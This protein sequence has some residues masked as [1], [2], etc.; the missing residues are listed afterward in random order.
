MTGRAALEA[1][2]LETG[3]SLLIP[4]LATAA[5][6]V[7]GTIAIAWKPTPQAVRAVAASMPFITRAKNVVVM[8]VEEERAPE[9]ADRLVR[10]LAWHGCQAAAVL[11]RN[12]GHAVETLFPAA[13][14]SADLLVMGGYGHSRLRERAFGGFI[15]RALED[16]P[17]RIDSP[18]N[19]YN[20]GAHSRNLS[21]GPHPA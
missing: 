8:T 2:L 5:P 9:K 16:A 6:L 14:Q 19:G 13:K 3:R 10:S 12:N 11:L 1:S 4:S 21:N 7:G 18:L 15:R 20:W 17:F